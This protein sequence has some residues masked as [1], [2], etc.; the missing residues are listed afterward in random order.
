MRAVPPNE[1]LPAERVSYGNFPEMS[2]N[3]LSRNLIR[4]KQPLMARVI[5]DV[6]VPCVS[7]FLFPVGHARLDQPARRKLKLDL[8]P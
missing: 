3:L 7:E 4:S 6:V 5:P 1:R 2:R 8:L